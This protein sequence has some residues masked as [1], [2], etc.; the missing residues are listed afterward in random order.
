[1]DDATLKGRFER[2]E[3]ALFVAFANAMAERV[4]TFTEC[5]AAALSMANEIV[6]RWMEQELG[7]LSSKYGREV[8]VDG[9]RYRRHTTGRR[10]YH[11][12]CGALEVQRDT[13]RLVGIHNGPTVVP[14]EVEAGILEQATP[15]LAA[16]VLRGFAA[17]PLRLYEDEMRAAHRTVPSRSTLE[18][19]GKRVGIVIREQLPLIEP[20]V[21]AREVVPREAHS[22][23]VGLDR[24]SIPMAETTGE[25]PPAPT[26]H[27][28]RRPQP[29]AV[30]YRMA[31]VATLA[32]NDRHG[33]VLT[34]IRLASTANEGPTELL[35]RL[36]GELEHVRGQ[37][38]LPLIIVQDGAPELWNLVEEWLENLGVR[39]EMKLIDRYHVEERL[40]ATCEVLESKPEA[41]RRLFEHWR[42]CLDRSDVAMQRICSKV[43]RLI[44]GTGPQEL[45]WPTI[46][47]SIGGM[48]AQI[49]EG[50]LGYFRNCATKIRYATARKRGFPIGSGVTEG[51]CKSVIAARFKRSGQRWFESGAVP[52][53]HLRALHLNG[54]L[55][56]V[57]ERVVTGRRDSIQYD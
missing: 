5:E 18:R 3:N 45:P 57:F 44:H 48:R 31:Y 19:I 43:K 17:M 49:A 1:V 50:H 27:V 21:R 51:A 35:E 47:P 41:A 13:Y 40:R 29:V 10:R 32:V 53:L 16:S 9:Q 54:R 7:R 15:A 38:R 26:G 34:S 52:C 24:T 6:R 11:S 30:A 28:R 36:G 12:L 25:S 4:G 23:S 39:A 14:L 42:R 22:I 56:G 46:A 55:D 2:T 37:R 20:L 33:D 8:I